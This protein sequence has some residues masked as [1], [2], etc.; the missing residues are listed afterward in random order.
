MV[1]KL[2][3]KLLGHKW[4]DVDVNEMLRVL[5]RHCKRCKAL[6]EWSLMHT[7]AKLR[8]FSRDRFVGWRKL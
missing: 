8:R 2:I 3:C 5:H 1:R 7:E 4:S 6:D